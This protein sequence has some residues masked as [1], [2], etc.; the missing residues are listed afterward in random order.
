MVDDNSKVSIGR[1]FMMSTDSYY[2]EIDFGST[3]EKR[4]LAAILERSYRDLFL[5]N[6]NDI[7][8]AIKW[9][10]GCKMLDEYSFAVSYTDCIDGL[11][12][13]SK[14]ITKIK[15]TVEV[16]EKYLDDPHAFKE[17]R[18]KL[19]DEI[20]RSCNGKGRLCS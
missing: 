14:E 7:K 19:K 9:F 17:E 5:N 1:I 2:E 4:L 20:E 6:R 16:I 12:L 15:Y 13:G 11:N 3:P 18:E 8:D 10:N